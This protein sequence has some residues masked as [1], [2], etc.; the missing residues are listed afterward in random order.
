MTEGRLKEV[1]VQ[2]GD[3]VRLGTVVAELDTALVEKRLSSAKAAKK[4]AEAAVTAADA[5]QNLADVTFRRQEKLAEEEV[6]SPQAKDEAN[7]RKSSAEAEWT[8]L[9]ASVEEMN[10]QVDLLAKEKDYAKIRAPFSGTVAQVY[11]HPGAMVDLEIPILRLVS[12]ELIVRFAL[13]IEL[14]GTFRRNAP[15]A[16]ELPGSGIRIGGVVQNIGSEAEPG[17]DFV[18]VEGV[19]DTADPR[20]AQIKSGVTVRVYLRP[21]NAS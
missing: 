20:P 18:V 6:V 17:L 2:M 12:D 10:A 4:E 5:A 8:R 13:P 7:A 21:A 19:L 1:P 11:Q 3:A 9:E 16:V 14:A 15:I